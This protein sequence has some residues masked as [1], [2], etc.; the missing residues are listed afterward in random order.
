VFFVNDQFGWSVAVFGDTVLVGASD[1]ASAATGVNGD[2][3]DNSAPGAGAAYV[4]TMPHS[5]VYCTAGI[6]AN[7]CAPSIGST[8]SPSLASA[9]GFT[10]DAANVERNRQGVFF[11]GLTGRKLSAWG[12]PAVGFLC[13]KAPTQRMTVHN[14]GGTSGVCTGA[15]SEDWL[16]YLSSHPGAL[17]QPFV[18]GTTVTV[19]AWYRDSLSAKTTNL[20][21][22]L[23]FVTLP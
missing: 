19:Q 14:S 2:P 10:I 13:V 17:G 8:G 15:L 3:T 23:E 16:A 1:E 5:V 4:F 18:A 20:S 9:S 7:G 12:T 22:A 11:Y 6:S 21:N